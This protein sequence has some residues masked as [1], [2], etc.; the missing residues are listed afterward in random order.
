M[1]DKSTLSHDELAADIRAGL[2][3]AEALEDHAARLKAL[4][5][6][7]EDHET[8]LRGAERLIQWFLGAAA[9]AGF[10]IGLLSDAIKKKLGWS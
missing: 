9:T 6:A 7:R 5:D 8:R 3:E 10:L 2:L 1:T 4:E